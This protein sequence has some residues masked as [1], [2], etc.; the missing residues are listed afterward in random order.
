MKAI[1]FARPDAEPRIGVLDGDTIRDAGPA[2]P[3]GFVPTPRRGRRSTPRP[4]RRMRSTRCA[5]CRRSS[6]AR[7]SRSG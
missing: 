5:C 7:S 1:R 6:R 3:Q 2:G 4:G